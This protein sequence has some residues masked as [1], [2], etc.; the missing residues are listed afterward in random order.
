MLIH[1]YSLFPPVLFYLIVLKEKI[2]IFSYFGIGLLLLSLL[3]LREKKKEGSFSWEWLLWVVISF[4][5]NSICSIMMKMQQVKFDGRYKNEMMIYAMLVLAVIFFTTGILKVK[6]GKAEI[7]DAALYGLPRG[8]MNGI[9]SFL[10]LLLLELIP[11]AIAGPLTAGGNIVMAFIL[12]V[13]YYHE[14]LS[15]SQLAGYLLGTI[16]VIFLNM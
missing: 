12:A 11:A 9:S 13:G 7:T 4:A 8:A 6:N 15:K 16:S 3:F 10:S 1:S 14:K 2:S 5:G